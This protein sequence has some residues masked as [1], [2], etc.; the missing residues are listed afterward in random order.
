MGKAV[1]VFSDVAEAQSQIRT[2]ELK[3]IKDSVKEKTLTESLKAYT[4]IP[5]INNE[6]L[7]S[8]Y[9]FFKRVFDII[10]GLVGSIILLPIMAIVKIVSVVHGDKESII[11]KQKRIGKGGKEIYIYKIRSM[12]PNAEEV[13]ENLMRENEHIKEEYERNKKIENDPRVTK[14]GAFIRKTSL[15]EFG[16]FVNILKGEM[17]V[18]GPRPY[19]IREKKDMGKYYRDIVESKPGLTGLWQVEGRSDMGFENRCRLDKFYNNH[20]GI[21]LDL[22]IFFKTFVVVLKRKGAR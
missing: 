14:I 1:T 6:N 9:M 19:L 3:Q 5:T 16:Q 13:L 2:V 7:N 17:S 21:W 11:F 18:V 15:D 8:F 20:K 22:K 12:V 10:I 4:D